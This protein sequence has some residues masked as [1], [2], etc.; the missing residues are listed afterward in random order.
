LTSDQ[1][2]AYVEYK[3]LS[4]GSVLHD[5]F[6]PG[7]LTRIASYSRGIPS[8]IDALCDRSL[9]LAHGRSEKQ[10]TESIVDDAWNILQSGGEPETVSEIFRGRESALA[11]RTITALAWRWRSWTARAL[12]RVKRN[13]VFAPTHIRKDERWTVARH[14]Y[15]AIG[16]ILIGAIVTALLVRP[17]FSP[18][19]KPESVQQRHV[20]LEPEPRSL[21]EK[22][23]AAPAEAL[24][25]STMPVRGTTANRT[26]QLSKRTEARSGELVYLHTTEPEDFRAVE[27]IG[28]VLRREGYIVGETI[29]T[30][31]NTEGDVRFFFASDRQAAQR[32]KSVVEA[33]LLSHGY[34]QRLQIL[35]RD[36]R[37]FR[38][39]APRKIEVW[40]PRLSH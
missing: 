30:R 12:R 31:N 13:L 32:V 11:E 36:G 35:E 10:I 23:P 7:A 29:F 26:S 20:L 40:L 24:E 6:G 8:T 15:Q 16:A 4:A 27:D 37:K 34:S 21:L 17:V 2:E 22:P 25:A 3:L 38:F 19:P 14:P 5:L 18:L 1:V 33:E 28:A 9:R 39:A